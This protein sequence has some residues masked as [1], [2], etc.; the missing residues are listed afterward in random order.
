VDRQRLPGARVHR[1][2]TES[3]DWWKQAAFPLPCNFRRGDG[4]QLGVL[5]EAYAQIG[6]S[7][8]TLAYYTGPV[9]VMILSPVVFKEKFT[10]GKLLGFL[11]VV[12]GMFVVNAEA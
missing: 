12:L 8:A 5:F 4:R 10:V 1:F 11:A 2:Q 3:T 7:L 6:V 9:I